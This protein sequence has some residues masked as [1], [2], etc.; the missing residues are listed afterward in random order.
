M[1]DIHTHILPGLDDGPQG[2]EEAIEMCR[3]AEADGIEC[4]V[5]TPHMMDGV[6]NSR[7]ED[8]IEKVR[9]L[10]GRIEG[11]I[12]LKILYG[13]DVHLT[14]DLI[15]RIRKG[16]IL[17]INDRNHLLLEFPYHILPPFIDSLLFDLRLKGITPIITHI[18]RSYWIQGGFH[19]VE[20]F[21]D[22]GALIQITAMSLTGGF[23]VLVKSLSE[24]LLRSRLV[25][26]IAS[27][28]HSQRLRPPGFSSALKAASAIIGEKDAC[29]M[30]RDTPLKV[31]GGWGE[32]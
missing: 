2:W 27:D 1:I 12:N 28:C 14:P 19:M 11:L 8:I 10:R 23:G 21:V 18:E 32:D 16:D 9:E 22:M 15:D 20:R 17:T 24:R 6:Y 31:I 29:A 13:A 4:L 26:I 7:R 25:H 5:A 30:V 3:L